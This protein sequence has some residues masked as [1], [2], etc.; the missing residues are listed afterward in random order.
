MISGW[1]EIFRN[2]NLVDEKTPFKFYAN[3][4]KLCSK[5]EWLK[6]KILELKLSTLFQKKNLFMRA[7]KAEHY[8]IAYEFS[9]GT[10]HCDVTIMAVSPFVPC[11]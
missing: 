8:M 6:D 5:I 10:G 1:R 7:F 4:A 2:F 9:L 3:S 11:S